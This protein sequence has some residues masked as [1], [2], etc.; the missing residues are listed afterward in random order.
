MTRQSRAR[1]LAFATALLV[2]LLGRYVFRDTPLA[3]P[4]HLV[5]LGIIISVVGQLG[6]LM[7]WSI[8]RDLRIEDFDTTIP[9]HGGLLDRLDSVIFAAPVY[10]HVLYLGW[11]K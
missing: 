4:L 8:K 9:G 10:F 5:T 1:W 7:F 3:N 2:V 6:D 11:H